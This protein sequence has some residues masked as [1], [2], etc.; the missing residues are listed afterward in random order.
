MIRVAGI[1][2]KMEFS[3]NHEYND[4]LILNET[5]RELRLLGAQVN[6]YK[7]EDIFDVEIKEDYIFSMV[8]S[9]EGTARLMEIAKNK[10][11]IINTPESVINCY[12][13]NLNRI[14]KKND[15]PYPESI[16]ISTDTGDFSFLHN[17][18][19]NIWIKRGDAH[20]TCREDVIPAKNNS[21]I[22]KVLDDFKL[23]KLS[24][25]SIQNHIEGN[26][27]KFYSVSGSGLFYWYLVDNQSDFSI[28]ADKLKKIA[29]K[30][31]VSL[32]LEIYGG[33]AV[34]TENSEIFII[35]MNDWP[36]F[37][38][39]RDIASEKI[40]GLIYNKIRKLNL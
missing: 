11:L 32:G 10:K 8:Q 31:A 26:R 12:R 16:C 4:F 6:I 21:D 27:V 13:Y 18:D 34:I 37:A 24:V 15:I 28:D 35:D 9:P 2:R 30:A 1:E 39:I 20:A 29:Y 40:A 33:E 23:R 3:P 7:E 38:P 5:A 17:F 36:S 25:S 14:M 19:K 22:K